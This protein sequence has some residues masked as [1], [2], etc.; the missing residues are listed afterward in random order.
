MDDKKIATETNF[1][2]DEYNV[3]N[4]EIINTY[5]DNLKDEI[6]PL[7]TKYKFKDHNLTTSIVVNL[8]WEY[9]ELFPTNDSYLLEIA[10]FLNLLL[11]STS[12]DE[13]IEL[14]Y[15]SKK[16]RIQSEITKQRI[17]YLINT[18][19]VEEIRDDFTLDFPVNLVKFY[20]FNKELKEQNVVLNTDQTV[21]SN[22][23]S[24]IINLS[25][26]L[27]TKQELEHVLNFARRKYGQVDIDKHSKIKRKDLIKTINK[28]I[29]KLREI[30][31]FNKSL[32]TIG[33][34]EA[35]FLYD[36]LALTGILEPD[37]YFNNQEKFQYIKRRF[38]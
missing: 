6:N 19:L 29:Y 32:K 33:T 7:I 9:K 16:I 13:S 14:K 30:D 10:E 37:P 11:R 23:N 4:N 8:I 18:L 1:Q 3:F 21:Q 22:Y 25:A 28:I 38:L 26:E 24:K 2:T 35:C 31:V 15:G 17:S 20:R 12:S 27:L 5:Y 36:I 34:K